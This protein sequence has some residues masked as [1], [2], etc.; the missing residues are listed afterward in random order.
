MPFSTDVKKSINISS[1]KKE[2]RWELVHSKRLS[3]G[4][5][6]YYTATGDNF[7]SASFTFS[8]PSAIIISALAGFA[9]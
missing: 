9:A 4:L 2:R 3:F 6:Q 7:F 1:E 5:V 8:R